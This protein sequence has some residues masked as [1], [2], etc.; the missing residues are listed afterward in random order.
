[1]AQ[2]VAFFAPMRGRSDLFTLSLQK[3]SLVF[4]FSYMSVPS[5]SW[6]KN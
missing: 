6:Q 4:N 2:T 1:M 3:T 5:L